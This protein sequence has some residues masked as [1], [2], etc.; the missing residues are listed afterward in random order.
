MNWFSLAYKNMKKSFQDYVAYFLT[1]IFGV[2][3]FY[4]FNSV[5]DQSIIE[6]ISKSSND[7][8][9]TMVFLLEGISIVVAF[10]LG[11]LIIYANNFLIRR[12][13]KEFGIY[14][15]LGMDKTDVSKI[16]VAE[17]FIVGL[18][19]LVTGIGIGVFLS[20]FMSI[21]VGKLFEADMSVYVFTVSGGA[22]VKTIINF[23]IIYVVVL[24]F[25]AGNLSKLR[26]I[27]LFSASKKT[28]KQVLRN[29][30]I[31]TIVFVISAIALGVAYYK[32]GFCGADLDKMDIVICILTGIVSTLLLFWSVAGFLLTMF[33]KVKPFYY[34]K[35]NSFVIRQFCNSV[36]TSAVSMGIICLMIFVTICT[37][38]TGFTAAHEFQENISN[39][40]PIDFSFVYKAEERV[41]DCLEREGMPIEQWSYEYREIPIYQSENVTW[42]TSLGDTIAA[43]KEQFPMARWY[44]PEDIM[45][46]SDYNTLAAMYGFPTYELSEDE[47]IVLC[48][49]MILRDIRNLNLEKGGIQKIGNVELKP[50]FTECKDGYICMSNT[51]INIGTILIPDAVVEKEKDNIKV[52]GYVLAGNYF[53]EDKNTREEIDAGLHKITKSYTEIQYMKENPIP[54]MI[55]GTK[56]NIRETNNGITMMVTFVVI[57]MGV[58][59]LLASAAL[60][61]LKALTESID[62]VENFKILKKIGCDESMLRKCLFAQI[63]VY[64]ILPFGVAIIHSIFGIKFIESQWTTFIRSDASWGVGVAAVVLTVLY[65]GYMLVTFKNSKRIVELD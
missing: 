25:H 6:S 31:A 27:D 61:A 62:S 35:L 23:V 48:D 3:I 64:F 22:I 46:I 60:L 42:E 40:T 1:L 33:S 2:A 20:Q 4:I 13:K 8:I 32:V 34:R 55:M 57:Y 41:T 28:E 47:Y 21:L 11:F 53:A 50:R 43:A 63:G 54:P 18:I 37:F 36:N 5:Q 12:R 51:R 17:T 16:L 59:F 58:V 24:L 14:L 38:S 39:L 9:Q 26:L 56:I 19:S 15:L 30:I 65:G 44:T 29:P 10:V 49:F 52:A 45:T 7:M